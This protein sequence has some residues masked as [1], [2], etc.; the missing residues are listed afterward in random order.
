MD[1]L[2]RSLS[3]LLEIIKTLHTQGVAFRSLIEKMDTKIPHGEFFFSLFGAL[4]QYEKVL[5]RE[6][7]MADLET[8]KKRGR[9]GGRSRV[10]E[11]ENMGAIREAVKTG[12]NK[13]S[14]CRNFGVNLSTLYDTL[15]REKPC[16]A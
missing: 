3:N 7:V 16:S 14:I 9:N 8:A 10:I 6:R 13:A 11:E 15:Y 5:P 1:R 4:A 12:A 2:G